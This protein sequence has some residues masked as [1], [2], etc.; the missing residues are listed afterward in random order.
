MRAETRI[1]RFDPE[2]REWAVRLA[3]L[4]MKE[5]D[6]GEAIA[7]VARKVGCTPATLR[8]WMRAAE[9]A[10]GIRPGVFTNPRRRIRDLE[11]QLAALRQDH[12]RLRLDIYRSAPGELLIGA[13]DVELVHPTFDTVLAAP[14]SSATC[15]PPSSSLM[16]S[17]EGSLRD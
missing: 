17:A 10:G 3:S 7:S 5:G 15:S 4:E 13:R 8:R 11:D 14:R 9:R 6:P 16:A 1:V 2:V 12:A